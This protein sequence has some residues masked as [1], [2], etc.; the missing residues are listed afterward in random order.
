MKEVLL[1]QK[2]MTKIDLIQLGYSEYMAKK[3]ITKAK[4]L[5]IKEGFD[6]YKNRKIGKVPTQTIEKIIGTKLL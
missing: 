5:L 4:K 2:I 6:Y 1:L 3:I